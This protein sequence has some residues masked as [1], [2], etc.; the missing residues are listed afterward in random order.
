MNQVIDLRLQLSCIVGVVSSSSPMNIQKLED[1]SSIDSLMLEIC[2]TEQISNLFLYSGMVDY[3]QEQLKPQFKS[4][5]S[6]CSWLLG[7]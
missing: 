4:C 1:A 3:H 2:A 5:V 7:Y 6:F